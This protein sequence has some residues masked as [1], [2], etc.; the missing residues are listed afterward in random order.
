MVLGKID[1]DVKQHSVTV[2]AQNVTQSQT[3]G[4]GNRQAIKVGVIE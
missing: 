3:G 2:T 1:K 4:N